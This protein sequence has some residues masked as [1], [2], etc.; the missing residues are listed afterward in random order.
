MDERDVDQAVDAYFTND[1]YYPRP[2]RLRKPQGSAL[3]D[4]DSLVELLQL[5]ED[6]ATWATFQTGTSPPV[7]SF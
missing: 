5:Y 4:A 6:G 3:P 2:P 1:P 7:Q